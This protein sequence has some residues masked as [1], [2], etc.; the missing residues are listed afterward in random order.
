ME[1][2][3]PISI[4]KNGMLFPEKSDFIITKINGEDYLCLKIG[5]SLKASL[6]EGFAEATFNFSDAASTD[7]AAMTALRTKMIVLRSK[8]EERKVAA[9]DIQFVISDTSYSF[10]NIKGQDLFYYSKNLSEVENYFDSPLFF[11][12]NKHVFINFLALRKDIK[13]GCRIF[14]MPDNTSELLGRKKVEPFEIW[15]RLM[16]SVVYKHEKVEGKQ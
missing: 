10:V 3:I 14:M 15:L 2:I 4:Y 5:D 16:N 11:R 12:A 9:E 13:F 1:T 7:T 6:I 8:T